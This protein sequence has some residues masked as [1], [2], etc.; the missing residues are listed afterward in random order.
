MSTEE[1]TQ[2]AADEAADAEF[3]QAFN[4]FSHADT[5]VAELPDTD[6]SDNPPE[7][8]TAPAETPQPTVEQLMAELEQTRTLAQD[9]EHRFKSEVGRQAA[10]QRQVQE[11]KTQLQALPQQA[12]TAT[13]QKKLSNR[14]AKIAEDFPELAEVLQEELSEAISTVRQ[15]LDQNLQPIRQR[16]QEAYYAREEQRVAEAYPNFAD[17][18]RSTQFHR[19]FAEQPEA[20]R[21]LAASPY[22]QD[23]IAVMDYFTGGAR[24]KQPQAVAPNPQVGEV[25]AR[26]QAAMQRNVSV[27][28]SAPAPVTDAPD[29]YE[30]AFNFYAKR[31]GK[32]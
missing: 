2:P 30:S 6:D 25:Q 1:L 19:W 14:M 18:V 13:Q 17:V 8:D 11:L 3:E 7:P 21:S 5:D 4:E 24:F 20:V 29:D 23:A 15:E 31:L 12:S 10:Y 9:F 28:N 22:A 32:K 16:E 26:R 27:K